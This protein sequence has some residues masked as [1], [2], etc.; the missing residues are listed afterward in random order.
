MAWTVKMA[1]PMPMQMSATH[2]AMRVLL[3]RD[4]SSCGRDWSVKMK[5]PPFCGACADSES[6]FLRGA[7]FNE[8]LSQCSGYATRNE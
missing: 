2:L 6:A 8:E 4:S 5:G 1:A 3:F 7:C